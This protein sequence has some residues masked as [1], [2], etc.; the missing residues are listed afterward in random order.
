MTFSMLLLVILVQIA[1]FQFLSLSFTRSLFVAR[2]GEPVGPEAD[3]VAHYLARAK[4]LRFGFGSFL[5]A[6]C[7]VIAAGVLS[8]PSAKIALAVVSVTSSVAFTGAIIRDRREVHAMLQDRPDGAVRLASLRPRRLRQWYHPA[9]ETL[10]VAISVATVAF[11]VVWDARG[12][13]V[14]PGILAFLALQIAFVFG[15]LLYTVRYGTTA[16]NSSALSS[17]RRQPEL[18]LELGERLLGA[19]LRYFMIA[20]VGVALLL[21][22]TI[23]HLAMVDAGNALEPAFKTVRWLLAGALLVA[24][25][26]YVARV[27]M[28]TKRALDRAE[29]ARGWNRAG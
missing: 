28:L 23:V 20:K 29:S 3:R 5:L 2:I 7:L 1:I 18:A 24:F 21:S 15:A 4:Q 14:R 17:L 9:W 16:R 25:A 6:A 11:L 12:Y 26:A 10:P 19:E 27:G 22:A 13:P 8:G